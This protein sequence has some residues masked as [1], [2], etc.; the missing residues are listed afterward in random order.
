MPRIETVLAIMNHYRTKHKPV[1][2]VSLCKLVP[3][4]SLCQ[5]INGLV[6]TQDI[7]R[8][9]ACQNVSIMTRG[10]NVRRSVTLVPLMFDIPE[11]QGVM[12]FDRT[13]SYTSPYHY[14]N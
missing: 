3:G 8:V 4:I 1:S 11:H 14:L 9:S 13:N 5:R 12:T 10:S 7:L 6:Y 2:H